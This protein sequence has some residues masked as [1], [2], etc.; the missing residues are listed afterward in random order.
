MAE[1]NMPIEEIET[2]FEMLDQLT[3]NAGPKDDAPLIWMR[4]IVGTEKGTAPALAFLDH[5]TKALAAPATMDV[6]NKAFEGNAHIRGVT[7]AINVRDYLKS[8]LRPDS[9]SG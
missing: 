9:A 5:L 3:S 2:T 8:V 7:R 4:K 1:N 6:L